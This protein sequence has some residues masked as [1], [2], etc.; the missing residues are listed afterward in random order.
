MAPEILA[1]KNHS[2]SVDYFAIGIIVHECILGFRPYS[3]KTRKDYRQ[4]VYAKQAR[5]KRNH[6]SSSEWSDE[7]IDFCNQLIQRKTCKRLGE[8]SI[9]EI[10]S[11]SWLKD[12][13]WLSI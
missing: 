7:A 6:V 1:R 2:Y 5:I 3:G 9:N 13:D 10:L 12:V 8:N 4:Q 11:H